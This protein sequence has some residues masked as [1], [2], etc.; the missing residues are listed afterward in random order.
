VLVCLQTYQSQDLKR[1]LSMPRL[2]VRK[3]DIGRSFLRSLPTSSCWL[4]V[5]SALFAQVMAST[6]AQT[7]KHPSLWELEPAPQP[8]SRP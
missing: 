6:L 8:R 5:S 2:L 3:L 1:A 7:L 4:D